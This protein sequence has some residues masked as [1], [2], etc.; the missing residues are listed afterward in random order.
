MNGLHVARLGVARGGIE[1]RQT[2]TYWPDLVQALFF[3]GV[4][5]SR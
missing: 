2:L 4:S 5:L 3:S 1:L